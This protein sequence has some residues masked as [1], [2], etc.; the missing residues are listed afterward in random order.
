MLKLYPCD[1]LCSNADTLPGKQQFLNGYC[2]GNSHPVH[3]R[4]FC[5]LQSCQYICVHDM[6]R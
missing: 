1:R 6:E 3:V 4:F 2:F 5:I